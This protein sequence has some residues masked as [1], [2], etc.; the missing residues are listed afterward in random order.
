MKHIFIINPAAGKGESHRLLL[1]RILRFVKIHGDDFEIHRTLNK[2]EVGAYVKS[3][4]SQGDPVRFYAVGGDGTICDVV[5]GLVGYPNAELG[6]IPCGS[7]N[8]FARNFALKELF[9][10]LEALTR[11]EAHSVDVI[12][13]N[14]H[15]CMNM[16]NVGADAQVVARSEELRKE[17]MA[18]SASYAKAALE[19]IPKAP[20]YEFE[21]AV[22]G[23]EIKREKFLLMA[24]GNGKFCGG[25]FRSCP[26]GSI[27]DGL[28]DIACVRSVPGLKLAPLLLKYRAG[29]YLHSR[30]AAPYF[31]YIKA[32]KFW[33]RPVDDVILSV[34]GE[35][36][37]CPELS[38]EIVPK[39][40]NLVVPKGSKIL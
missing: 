9:F 4:A 10:N 6:F 32:K 15:Y 5:N 23:G 33:L 14:D 22:E 24:I 34:D 18:G 3:R 13:Y 29:T 11:G 39:A 1:P 35:L 26:E 38:I 16:L 37:Q 28:L 12:K 20:E 7:G 8:D 17:G 27:D 25:G 21:Y 31:E 30:S 19:I 36:E 40:I 2:Q